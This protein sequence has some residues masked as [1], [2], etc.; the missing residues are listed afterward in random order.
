MR[1]LV[2]GGA[3]FIGS[4]FIHYW[5]ERHPKDQIVNVDKM[6]YAADQSNLEGLDAFDHRIIR[7]DIADSK[8]MEAAVKD[9]DAI[10][11]F[12]A[13]SHVDNSIVSS[14]EFIRSNI[15][16]VQVLLNAARK[17]EKRFHQ[18]STDEVYGSLS[19]RSKRKFNERSRY[20]PKN[21]YSATK[22]AAD[23]LVNAYF[24]TYGMKVTISNCSNNYGP[25]QNVEKLIPKAI[26]NALADREIPVYAKGQ[27]VR[28]WIYVND[29]CSAIEAILEKGRYGETYLVGSD[30]QRHNIDVV[31][32]ILHYLGKGDSLIRY[33]KD[34]PGHDMKYAID[35]SKITKELGWKPSY[36]FEESLNGTIEWYWKRA[37][38]K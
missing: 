22:A 7:E 12:A 10:V 9:V 11:N 19:L 13:E 3:G 16:G 36:T 34:R 17:F 2:T 14:D 29:H 4:N 35:P 15:V 24:N 5:F 28:D 25:R 27:N 26:T 23:H 20:N 38:A 31:K 18:I 6:T 8:A 21:P 32:H 30:N 1:L 33:V 37:G